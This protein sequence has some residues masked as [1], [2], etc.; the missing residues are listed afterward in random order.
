MGQDTA[1]GGLWQIQWV[2]ET[3][4][5]KGRKCKDQE[6]MPGGKGRAQKREEE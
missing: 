5:S 2:T 1:H 6:M 3:K 4:Q